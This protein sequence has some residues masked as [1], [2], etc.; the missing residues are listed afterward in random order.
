MLEINHIWYVESNKTQKLTPEVLRS[1]EVKFS[2]RR[3]VIMPKI[4]FVLDLIAALTNVIF[5]FK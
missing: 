4:K 5:H 1:L 2:K 3:H